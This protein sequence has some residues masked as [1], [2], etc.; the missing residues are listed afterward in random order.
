[1]T[2]DNP[3]GTEVTF[4]NI[5]HVELP[6]KHRISLTLKGSDAVSSDKDGDGKSSAGDVVVF[7]LTVN[8]TG[9]VDLTGVEVKATELE[10]LVCQQ[11]VPAVVGEDFWPAG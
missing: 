11:F 6:S 1:M 5:V 4:S 2:A 3:E 10:G 9:S 7:T 8:N